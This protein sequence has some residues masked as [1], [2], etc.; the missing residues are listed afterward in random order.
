MAGDGG[1]FAPGNGNARFRFPP[2]G[3]NQ[4]PGIQPPRV[5]MP[6]GIQMP[7]VKMPQGIQPAGM[8]MPQAQAQGANAMGAGSVNNFSVPPPN[9][10]GGLGLGPRWAIGYFVSFFGVNLKCPF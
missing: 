3:L 9:Y 10:G 6:Q 1:N 2:P 8:M 7:R 5:N 4:V